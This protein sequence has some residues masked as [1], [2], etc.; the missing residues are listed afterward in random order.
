[1]GKS[2]GGTTGFKYFMDLHFIAGLGR[3]GSSLASAVKDALL[4]IVIGGRNAWEGEQTE[5]GTIRVFAPELFGG[6]E[7]EG[8]ID[9]P[10]EVM[11]GGPE[12]DINAYLQSIQGA[13]QS[14]YRGLF[15]LLVKS[16]HVASNNPYVKPWAMLRRRITGDWFGG[17]CWYE[18]KAPILLTAAAPA[19]GGGPGVPVEFVGNIGRQVVLGPSVPVI[20]PSL[21]TVELAEFH[22]FPYTLADGAFW[23][24]RDN[25][26]GLGFIKTNDEGDDQAALALIAQGWQ[27]GETAIVKFIAGVLCAVILTTTNDAPE[28]PAG[29]E[30]FPTA[31]FPTASSLGSVFMWYAPVYLGENAPSVGSTPAVPPRYC[32]NPAHVIYQCI[33][34][35]ENGL[36]YPAAVI[37]EP[38]FIK[39]ANQLY[40]E[41]LGVNLGWNVQTSIEDFIAIAQDH[42]GGMMVRDRRTGL[43][44]FKLL[45]KDYVIDDL[46]IYGPHNCRI[47]GDAQRPSPADVVNELQVTYTDYRDG[48]EK[49]T[50]VR[51]VA[52]QQAVGR[53]ISKPHSLTGLPTESLAQRCGVRDLDA[54]SLPLWR[55]DLEF[56]RS[57]AV[58]EPGDVF[59]FIWPPLGLDIVLRIPDE[60]NYGNAAEGRVRGKVIEDVFSLPDSVWTGS[61]GE[62]NPGPNTNPLRAESTLVEAPYRDLV[63]ALT[64]AKLASLEP[65]TAY[66]GAIAV[67][68][69]Q[70]QTT[71]ELHTR[72]PPA[73]L[74]RVGAGD[75]AGSALLSA[76]VAPLDAGLPVTSE[77]DLGRLEVGSAAFLGTGPDQEMVRI[78]SVNVGMIGVA[79]GCGDTVP[80]SWP[81]G[82]RLWGYDNYGAADPTEYMAGETI[83]GKAFSRSPAGLSDDAPLLSITPVGRA[84]LPYPPGNVKSN[85]V[86]VLSGDPV[87]PPAPTT[88]DPPPGSPPGGASANG[89]PAST[90]LGPN[91][92]YADTGEL[93]I[94][95]PTASGSDEIGPDGDF[96]N[97]TALAAW[98]QQNG[99][100]L[101]PAKWTTVGGRAQCDATLLNQ[102]FYRGAEQQMPWLQFPRYVVEVSGYLQTEAGVTASIG[103]ARDINFQGGGPVGGGFQ[104]APAEYLVETLVTYQY[105]LAE[106][107]PGVTPSNSFVTHTIMPMIEH[108][109]GILGGLATFK[110]VAMTVVPVPFAETEHFPDH[111]DLDEGLEGWGIFPGLAGNPF[112][113]TASGGVVTMAPTLAYATECVVYCKTPL[114][115]LDEVGKYAHMLAEVLSNDPT[116][117]TSSLGLSTSGG[118]ALGLITRNEAGEVF[119]RTFFAYERGDWTDR[120]AFVRCYLANGVAGYT[121]HWAARMKAAPGRVAKFRNPRLFIT[122][123]PQD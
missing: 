123:D 3:G 102:A 80:S 92:G 9:A 83:Q 118:V 43:F 14:A 54:M 95:F 117:L 36:G 71:F 56:F 98:T 35:P 116:I 112:G 59:R 77:V 120:E 16:G 70:S 86:L 90:T 57:A 33:T 21:C 110:D 1:M 73:L 99:Q 78:V 34:D 75:F 62:P 121:Q 18:E 19:G 113:V 61:V 85:G 45:R 10:L 68:A 55:F 48:E 101:D 42:A 46:P 87:I 93:P 76:A 109:G 40:D 11:F 30:W 22:G 69:N 24:W 108:N 84:W 115:G 96:S 66:V 15:G 91:G 52:A 60:L 106:E 26:S 58:L 53:I 119:G 17:S 114:V 111:L 105:L 4:G 44:K 5:N 31:A 89:A 64:P 79:R 41:G 32:M 74:V 39:A 63:Q 50:T 27:V 6:D 81:E 104:S 72:I 29:Y 12:Q 25:E 100:P 20:G 23:F 97:P 38:S 94:P 2:S 37:D 103:V 107:Y 88:P 28:A 47:I 49:T 122:D 82:T 13:P 65:D 8:G 67:R 7:K 51:N